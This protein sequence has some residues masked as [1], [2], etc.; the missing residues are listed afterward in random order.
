M[1]ELISTL[2]ADDKKT[3]IDILKSY[4]NMYRGRGRGVASDA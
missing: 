3:V 1:L 4:G 2:A